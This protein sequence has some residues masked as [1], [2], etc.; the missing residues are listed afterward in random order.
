MSSIA[1]S[2]SG[3][4]ISSRNF[5]SDNAVVGVAIIGGCNGAGWWVRRQ[6]VVIGFPGRSGGYRRPAPAGRF[7]GIF[8][9]D[10]YL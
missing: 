3:S 10:Y 1:T 2:S 6:F 8:M 5:P 4:L 7:F 9:G